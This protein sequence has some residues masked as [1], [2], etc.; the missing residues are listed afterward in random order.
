MFD[1][2]ALEFLGFMGVDLDG[3]IWRTEL[4]EDQLTY[5]P[6]ERE[7]CKQYD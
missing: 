3:E 6:T 4:K 1:I 5:V 7:K 2:C